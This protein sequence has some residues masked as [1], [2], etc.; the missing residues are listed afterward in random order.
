[1]SRQEETSVLGTFGESLTGSMFRCAQPA[2]PVAPA[3][4]LLSDNFTFNFLYGTPQHVL[5][6]DMII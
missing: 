6:P 2:A 5:I 3:H 1:M 4:T